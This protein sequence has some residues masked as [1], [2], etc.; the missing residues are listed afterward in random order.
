MACKQTLFLL[1]LVDVAGC[2][3]ER[4]FEVSQLLR[5]MGRMGVEGEP[6]DPRM[7]RMIGSYL[8]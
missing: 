1:L 6:V 4:D 8:N 3:C 7:E 2:D 5:R